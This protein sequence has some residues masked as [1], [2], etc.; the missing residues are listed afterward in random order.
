MTGGRFSNFLDTDVE[1]SDLKQNDSKMSDSESDDNG[2]VLADL[3]IEEQ[4]A[5]RHKNNLIIPNRYGQLQ[6]REN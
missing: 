1:E 5:Q 3:D 6:V 2:K 4:E